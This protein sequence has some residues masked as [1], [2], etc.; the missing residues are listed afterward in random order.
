MLSKIKA[1]EAKRANREPAG[2]DHLYL[3][4][5]MPLNRP[6]FPQAPVFRTASYNETRS[7]PII[8]KPSDWLGTVASFSLG[9][10][11]VPIRVIRPQGGQ[12]D[13]NLT[14]FS[15]SLQATPATPVRVVY[16]SWVPE[17]SA[18][19]ATPPAGPVPNWLTNQSDYQSFI[20][21]NVVYFSMFSYQSLVDGINTAFAASFAVASLDAGWNAA[22]TAPPFV[23]YSASTKLFTLWAQT[24]YDSTVLANPLVFFNESLFELFGGAW[25]AV[26]NAF[27]GLPPGPVTADEGADYRLV[28]KSNGTTVGSN[29]NTTATLPNSATPG[30]FLEQ[31]FGSLSSWLDIKTIVFQTQF[32][33]STELTPATSSFVNTSGGQPIIAS[34]T[35]DS[36]DGTDF[37]QTATYVPQVYRWFSIDGDTPQRTFDLQVSWQDDRG[38]TFPLQVATTQSVSVKMLF[39]RRSHFADVPE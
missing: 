11:A 12:P 21:Q 33:C 15:V 27:Q 20:S 7:Q 19:A 8:E 23:T 16:V 17:T 38:G 22:A 37:R 5:T 18:A 35:V 6:L 30:F 32:P 10:F 1:Y 4:V 13:V 25:R 39:V 29:G 34:F 36:S 26:Q 31:E 14:N 28:I 3:N 9:M 2:Q 24:A